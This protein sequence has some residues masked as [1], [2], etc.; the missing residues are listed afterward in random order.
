MAV[1]GLDAPQQFP[2]VPAADQHLHACM[3]PGEFSPAT[4]SLNP[5]IQASSRHLR[6]GLHAVGQHLQGAFLKELLLLLFE[7]VHRG[8]CRSCHACLELRP[9]LSAFFSSLRALKLADQR[10]AKQSEA[11]KKISACGSFS[12]ANYRRGPAEGWTHSSRKARQRS[13]GY[14]QHTHD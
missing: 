9:P 6:V 8:V 2:V 3:H 10:N 4:S 13:Q 1:K 14:P 11:F 12:D 7:L 5:R